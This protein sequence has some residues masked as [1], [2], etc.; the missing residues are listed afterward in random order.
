MIRTFIALPL[1]APIQ[2]RLSELGRTVPGARCVPAKQIHLTIRFIGEV[3][4]ALFR[5]IKEA[6]AQVRAAPIRLSIRGVGH[7]PPRGNPRVL[8]AGV[9]PAAAVI[10]LRQHINRVLTAIGIPPEERKYHPHVTIAR[11]HDTPLRRVTDFLTGNS[12]LQ[13]PPFTIDS[14]ALFSSTL[15]AKGAVHRLEDQYPLFGPA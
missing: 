13:S 8:W 12:L 3:E 6:L 5:A 14:F 10:D 9:E 4:G 15:S 1:E 2:T 11:L 7:F